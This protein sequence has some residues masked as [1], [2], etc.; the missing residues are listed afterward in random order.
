M[1]GVNW[2]DPYTGQIIS[3][4]FG[5]EEVAKQHLCRTKPWTRLKPCEASP[6]STAAPR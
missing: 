2:I 3:A 1:D 6:S 5:Y 4:P